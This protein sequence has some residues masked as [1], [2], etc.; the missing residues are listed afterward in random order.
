[1]KLVVVGKTR[2]QPGSCIT[3]FDVNSKT[4]WKKLSLFSK[5]NRCIIIVRVSGK[6][7]LQVRHA[8]NLVPFCPILSILLHAVN[9]SCDIWTDIRDSI[10]YFLIRFCG[11]SH[12]ITERTMTSITTNYFYC[13]ALSLCFLRP[14]GSKLYQDLLRSV[15]LISVERKWPLFSLLRFG[16]YLILVLLST[17]AVVPVYWICVVDTWKLL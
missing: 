4:K 13:L 1:M 14:T 11:R 16:R 3:A 9:F 6:T 8:W 2:W 5:E 17:L 7:L 15:I 12:F 10:W